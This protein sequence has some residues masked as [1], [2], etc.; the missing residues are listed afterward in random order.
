MFSIVFI[1][2]CVRFSDFHWFVYEFVHKVLLKSLNKQSSGVRINPFYIDTYGKN[3]FDIR[4]F[5]VVNGLQEQI[6]FMNRGS[7]VYIM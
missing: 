4:T 5:R 7:T 6:K 3:S 1:F 2:L